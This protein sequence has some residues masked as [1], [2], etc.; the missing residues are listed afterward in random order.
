MYVHGLYAVLGCDADGLLSLVETFVREYKEPEVQNSQVGGSSIKLDGS[1]SA[2]VSQHS[3]LLP[4][5]PGVLK[6]NLGVPIIVVCCKVYVNIFVTKY[7][8]YINAKLCSFRP[9]R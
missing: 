7:R 9:T 6:H 2:A 5:G 4:L 8:H 3:V 1:V